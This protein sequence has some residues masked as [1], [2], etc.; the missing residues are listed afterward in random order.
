Q[1]PVTLQPSDRV[2][3]ARDL[4]ERQ[5]ISGV[6]ITE[7]GGKLVGIL[8]KRDLRFLE[9]SELEI[10]QVMTRDNLVTATGSVSL[11]EAERILTDK[12]VEK[13]LL[14][15]DQYKLTGLITIKDIDMMKR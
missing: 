2:R 6:P 7:A 3:A 14:V 12:K 11:E 1:D 5:N 13:L 10:S 8:T 15:D 4:M 9:S